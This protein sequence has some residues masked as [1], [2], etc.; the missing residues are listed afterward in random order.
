MN[1]TLT[2][3]KIEPY[4]QFGGRC[5]EALEFYR[6]SLDGEVV[7]MMRFKDSP[8]PCEGGP[9]M[10]EN[11]IMHG[12]I[13][14]GETMLM[15]TDF[16]CSEGGGQAGFSG[17]SLSLSATDEAQANKYFNALSNGGKVEMPLGK[18]FFSPCFGVVQDKFGVNWMVIVPA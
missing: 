14:I 9:K 5:E 12:S 15:A 4:L 13:K 2:T 16:G 11:Q 6:K 8:E 7:M 1:A 3:T 18:T 10:D 17:F